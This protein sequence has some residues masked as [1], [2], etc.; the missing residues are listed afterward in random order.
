MAYS[1]LEPIDGATRMTAEL[2]SMLAAIGGQTITP[3]AFL[4]IPEEPKPEEDADQQADL[5]ES[6]A[7]SWYIQQGREAEFREWQ[8]KRDGNS[9]RST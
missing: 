4:R 9:S 2:C 1:Q 7:E 3:N 8:A 6:I 5:F